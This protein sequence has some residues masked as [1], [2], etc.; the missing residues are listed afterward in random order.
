MTKLFLLGLLCLSV[1]CMVPLMGS[2]HL[3]SDHLHHDASVSCSTCMG[4]AAMS[5]V[6]VLFA[7][8]G[9][10]SLIIPAAPLLTLVVDQFHPPRV[11]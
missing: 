10:S 4:S 9:F 2:H 11:R 5:T 8:L 7:L 6:G 1:L 3:A